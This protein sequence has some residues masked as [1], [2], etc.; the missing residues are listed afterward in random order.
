MLQVLKIIGFGL[1]MAATFL[2]F[3]AARAETVS[4]KADLNAQN[5]V[6][7]NSSQA[8]GRGEATLDTTTRTLTWTSNYTELSGPAIGA[9]FHG[10]GEAGRNAGITLHFRS[11]ASPIT[12]SQVVSETQAAEILSGRWY[13]NIH[14]ERNPGGEIR[15]QLL[16]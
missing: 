2:A 3:D 5:E 13:I 16:R 15:G 1:A 8:T 14:T 9:H 7:P 4:F 11:T 12:G 6:P 10:P